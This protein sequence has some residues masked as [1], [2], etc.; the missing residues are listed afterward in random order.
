ME[1]RHGNRLLHSTSPYLKQHAYNPVDWYPWGV[2]ALERARRE[3]KPI[4]LSI[5]YSTCHWC[6]VM[7]H[8]TFENPA[9][10]AIMN[11]H[12]INIKVDREERPDL[13]ETY[14]NAVYAL[15][16]SGGW[17]LSVFLTPDLKPFYG[18]TYF[19]PDDRGGLPGF[20][21]LLLALSQAYRQ[22]REQIASLTQ[23]IHTHLQA[24]AELPGQGQEV[25]REVLDLMARQIAGNLDRQNGGLGGAPKFPRALEMEFLLTYQHLPREDALLQ[26]LAFSLEKMARGGIYDQLGGG[27]HRYS[28]DAAWVVPHFEK[29]LYDNALLPP[30]YL[31][32]HQLTGSPLARRVAA[33][34]LDF[35]LREMTAPE[36]GFYAAW[37]A[38]SEGVEGKYYVW[39]QEEIASEVEAQDLELVTAALGVSREGNFEGTNVLTRPLSRQELADRFSRTVEQVEQT[40]EKAFSRLRQARLGRVPPHRDEKVVVSWNGL[41]ISGLARGAQVL[42]DRKYHQAAARAAR[43]ILAELFKPEGLY[44]IWSAGQTSVPAFAEDYALLAEG[45]LDLFETDF[46]PDWVETA[47]H[48]LDLL[49]EKFL[50]AA[51]GAYFYVAQDQEAALVRSKSIFDQTLP[52]ANSMAVR[53][54][55]RLHRL[56]ESPRYQDRALAILRRFQPQ[57]R[58][59]PAGFAHLCTAA[60]LHLTPPLDLTVVGDP[61][62]PAVQE[63][64]RAAHRYF[65]PARQL[66]VKNPADRDRL[67]QLVPAVRTYGPQ[68]QPV[69]YLCHNYAC[70]AGIADPEELDRQLAELASA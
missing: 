69:A 39:S 31:A 66:V 12:F 65:L 59:N 10:A 41:M 2:E 8:E 62:S 54:S 33:A 44:R 3:D 64:V 18:G 36:G 49:D 37:D 48:L 32:L 56:T 50:D 35:V 40:L 26:D 14:M 7:A 30:L 15:T 29:M 43:F 51:D 70:R 52:S 16:G 53:V 5:G 24:M 21:R 13:D 22:N 57:A 23:K 4:F 6:H 17:P 1:E 61:A 67:E 34:T 38:D 9:V 47:V 45:L 20:T 19:P 11:Q 58:E 46:N 60:T 55:L 42:G 28:V 68:D 25:T 63:M 27:F